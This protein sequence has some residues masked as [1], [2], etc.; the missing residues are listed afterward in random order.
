MRLR[1]SS[2]LFG[3]SLAALPAPGAF[4]QVYPAKNGPAMTYW[5]T[6]QAAWATRYKTMGDTPFG[7]EL[8]RRT[9]YKV[10]YVHPAAAQVNQA[11]N[12]MLASGDMTDMIE[13]NFLDLPGGP[14]KFIKDGYI[15]RL[16]EAFAK[17]APNLM[18]YLKAH[19]DVDKMVKTDEGNYYGFPFIRTDDSLMVYQ[20]PIIRQDWLDDLGLKMPETIDDWTKVLTAFKDK[21]GATAPFTMAPYWGPSF[22]DWKSAS[23]SGAF[24]ALKDWYVENGKVKYGPSEPQ[25]KDFLNLFANWYKAGLIDSNI[26]L[27]D[28]KTRDALMVAGKVGATVGNVGGGIGYYIK[29]MEG[30]DAKANWV[31]APYPVLKRGD[32]PKFGQR[33]LAY[34]KTI[35]AIS[36]QTKNLEAACRYLDYGYSP[37]GALYYNFGTPE[38]SYTL[39]NGYPTY[40]DM[41]MKNPKLSITEAMAENIRGNSGGPF[42]QDKRYIQQFAGLPVQQAAIKTWSNTDM[43]KYSLPNVSPDGVD[44][45]EMSKIM[46]EVNTFVN[47]YFTKTVIGADSVANFDK[48]IATLKKLNIDRAIAI[49]QKAYDLYMKR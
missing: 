15:L 37:D 22:G 29:L 31:G 25:Y 43:A 14:D 32:K 10:T 41:I 5:M 8:N 2:L 36:A 38:V 21:K 47:E 34:N 49:Q 39:V 48:Y 12:L 16:N 40:T 24:G 11:F 4:A 13:N 44:V 35:V 19:P 27:T 33:D 3:L 9:G 30:K 17:W 45:N 46:S 26:A 18:A 23:F 42:L 6:P 20:G 7:V 28:A 1:I